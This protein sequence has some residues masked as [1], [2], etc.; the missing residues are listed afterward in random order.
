MAII[1]NNGN[2]F[3]GTNGDDIVIGEEF[4]GSGTP[5]DTFNGFGGNDVIYGDHDVTFQD[6]GDSNATIATAINIDD[7][8]RWSTKAN[9]DVANP[10]VPYTTVLSQAGGANQI[11]VYAVTIGAGQTLTA[12]IDYGAGIFGGGSFDTFMTLRN[13][14]GTVLTS[15]DDALTTQGGRGSTSG[16]DS[17]F[18]FTNNTGV[19]AVFYISID[20]LGGGG[21][22]NGGTYMLNVSVTGHANTNVADF[23]NDII[24]GGADADILYG[25]DGDDV[26]QYDAPTDLASGEVIL[27]GEGADTVSIRAAG[28]FD[29]RL[30]TFGSINEIEFTNSAI[31]TVRINESQFSSVGLSPLAIIDGFAGGAA[32]ANTF[33]VYTA[34]GG[35][36]D[37]SGLN[38]QDWTSDDTIR[39]L[40]NLGSETLTGDDVFASEIGGGNGTDILNGGAANDVLVGGNGG[41]SLN[42]GGG[43]DIAIYSS[44]SAVQIN[45]STG[46]A[47]GGEAAGDTFNSIETLIGSAFGDILTGN[48]LANALI[49]GDGNDILQGLE[50]GDVL[51]GGNGIDTATYSSS[52][53]TVSVNLTNLSGAGGHAADDVLVGIENV[54]GSNFGD[55][56]RGDGQANELSGVGGADVLLGEGGADVLFG[57]VGGDLMTG[58]A[59]NDLFLLDVGDGS[60]QELIT[61]FDQNGDDAFVFRGFGPGFDFSDFSFI[62]TNN[63]GG[64]VANDLV[65]TAVGWGGSAILLNASGAIDSGDFIFV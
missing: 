4:S 24:N 63:D 8:A 60:F 25:L 5:A 29:F 55:L 39:V 19:A 50:G 21:I 40:G 9:P 2:V 3:N 41:D 10:A 14:G 35:T 32:A 37:L 11:D 17:F 20:Q 53:D 31:N 7:S 58:G 13:A 64:P 51:V 18:T 56:I 44:S 54:I 59:D 26:F 61:D 6:I 57:G 48:S 30:A 28:I 46:F 65:M 62:L 36:A 27:G 33:E 16:L 12:D 43:F 42:G 45:L 22:P 1:A 49:G 47:S 23:S 34:S 38:F 52:L 15:N